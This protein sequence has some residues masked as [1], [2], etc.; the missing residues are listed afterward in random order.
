MTREP[1]QQDRPV[2]SFEFFPPKNEE[3]E[4]RFWQTLAALQPFKP[5]FISITYG[6][7]GSSRENTSRLV[8][9]AQEKTGI[10]TVAHLT[11]I[12][13]S[14]ENLRQLLEDYSAKGIR[15]ILAL[16]GDRPA[17][18]PE[19]TLAKGTF[20]NAAQFVTRIRAEFPHLSVGV[21]AYP[22]A[23]PEATSPQADLD[24]FKSKIDAGSSFAITQ[25]FFDNNA[26][27]RFVANSRAL[28]IQ[29][30]IIPGIMP[31]T[32]YKQ[33]RRFAELCGAQVPAWLS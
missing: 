14:W 24:Y 27:S 15:H 21:A 10:P 31:V 30:P 29:V 16:R 2:L 26:Y 3:G 12:G 1:F 25:F 5:D 33:I 23:H 11:C 20:Q 18:M 13:D 7:G 4:T 6:A 17:T 32:D 8:C 28:G 22:E 9:E 19:E